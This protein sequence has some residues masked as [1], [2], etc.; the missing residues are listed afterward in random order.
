[1]VG[2]IVGD[3]IHHWAVI[4]TGVGAIITTIIVFISKV[5]KPLIKALQKYNQLCERVDHLYNEFKP[6]GGSSVKDKIDSM[7]VEIT[8][9]KEM[10]KAVLVD[11]KDA[12][13]KT[14]PVGNFTWVNR[15]YSRIVGHTPSELMGT[16]WQNAVA[17]KDRGRVVKD[18]NEAVSQNREFTTGYRLEASDGRLIPVRTRSYKMVNAQGETIGYF[19]NIRVLREDEAEMYSI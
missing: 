15:T 8:N 14:D 12:L 13:F 11:A 1:M 17:L 16:G 19:G 7:S 18:W 5:V 3:L 10:Q 9:V 6:N 4:S 2:Q